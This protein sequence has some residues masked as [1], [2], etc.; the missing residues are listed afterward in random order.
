MILPCGS[1]EGSGQASRRY[2]S[3]GVPVSHFHHASHPN[4]TEHT[5]CRLRWQYFDL[6]T[7]C[8]YRA[9]LQNKVSGFSCHP[10]ISVPPG[11]RGSFPLSC[12]CH[13]DLRLIS[14]LTSS[15]RN[16]RRYTT[17]TAGRA[18]GQGDYKRQNNPAWLDAFFLI[19]QCPS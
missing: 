2:K 5:S 18:S 9:D 16:D 3:F 10:L 7:S 8:Q 12:P 1:T 14:S 4:S 13:N 11:I 6:M 15:D 17:P 19:F